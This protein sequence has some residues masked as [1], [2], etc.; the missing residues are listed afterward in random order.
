MSETLIKQIEDLKSQVNSSS[1]QIHVHKQVIGE[2]A[3]AVLTLRTHVLLYQQAHEQVQKLLESANAA[4]E[5]EKKKVEALTL[6]LEQIKKPVPV[7]EPAQQSNDDEE[8]AA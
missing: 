6:E 3:E 5:V 7:E 1:A 2:Q 4:L 8:A